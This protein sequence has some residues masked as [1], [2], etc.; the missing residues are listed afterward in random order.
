M[1]VA[2][3]DAV[4]TGPDT[5]QSGQEMPLPGTDGAEIFA[6]KVTVPRPYTCFSGS[7]ASFRSRRM[8]FA[9]LWTVRRGMPRRTLRT[10]VFYVSGPSCVLLSERVAFRFR[11][12]CLAVRRFTWPLYQAAQGRF[13]PDHLATAPYSLLGNTEAL[14]EL[15][16]A[17]HAG[18]L[19]T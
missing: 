14:G 12:P 1:A 11:R 2:G 19:F 18:D 16:G 8:P 7:V 6:L 3:R 13:V 10:L 9:T 4:A 17:L 5:S 15:A